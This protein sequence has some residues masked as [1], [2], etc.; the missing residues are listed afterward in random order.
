M[1]DER[2]SLRLVRT[3]DA[4]LIDIGLLT[5][6]TG[7]MIS[8]QYKYV[9]A[10]NSP[11]RKELLAGLGIDFE[12]RVLSDIDESYPVTLPVA[13]IAEFI[14]A[15]KAE[16]YRATMGA[17]ELIITADTVVI[18]GDEV[19]GKPADK[20][21]AQRMLHRTRP[22]RHNGRL[23]DHAPAAAPIQRD[24]RGDVQGA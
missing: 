22:P 9:L 1:A 21:D 12:V 5:I 10:S 6:E 14:A 3:A 18:C 15:K 11:R 24:H 23:S 19:M 7:E 8:N 20:A 17:D 13:D 2:Y 4:G 16:A